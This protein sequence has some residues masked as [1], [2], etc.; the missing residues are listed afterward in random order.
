MKIST[1]KRKLL[2]VILGVVV[3]VLAVLLV[4][5][6]H[7]QR[8]TLAEGASGGAQSQ[9]DN[10]DPT[11]R[12]IQRSKREVQNTVAK[13]ENIVEEPEAIVDPE[14]AKSYGVEVN[15]IL[16]EGTKVEVDQESW[17]DV[18]ETT[19]MVPTTVKLPDGEEEQYAAVVSK[20]TRGWQLT[21]TLPI[22]EASP[23]S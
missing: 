10:A 20:T 3:V 11:K 2:F 16:P 23:E 14:V 21:T 15:Q 9:A 4:W 22:E 12:K 1:S 18:D 7:H 8:T 6:I 13:L 19:A 5:A 17:T